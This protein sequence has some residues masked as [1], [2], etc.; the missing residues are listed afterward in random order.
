MTV[1]LRVLIVED[2]E[3]DALLLAEALREGGYEPEYERVDSAEALNAA[4]DAREWDVIL[5]DYSMPGFGGL[6]ALKITREKDPDIPFILVSGTVG[7]EIAV[8]AMRVGCHDYLLKSHL[9]R[10]VPAIEREMESARARWES[11]RTEEALRR[12][13]WLLRRSVTPTDAMSPAPSYGDLTELNTERTILDSVGRETLASIAGDAIDLLDTSVAIYERNGDYAL[14]VFASG[15]CRFLDEAARRLCGTDDNREA[16]TC[17]RWLCHEACW[18]ASAEAAIAGGRPTDVACPGGIRL[19]A[20][21]IRAGE[22]IIGAIN[23]GYGDPP[24]DPRQLERIAAKYGVD[25]SPLRAKAEE[26]RSRPKYVVELARKKL[27]F[28][29]TL[30]GEMVSRKRAEEALRESEGR[31]KEAQRMGRIGHW[32]FDIRT[33][34]IEWS[35]MVYEIYERDPA[36]GPPSEAEEALYYPPED[37]KRLR[38]SARKAIETGEPYELDVQ[39]NLPSGKQVDVVAMGKP[40]MDSDGDVIRLIGTVQDITQRKRAEEGLQTAAQQWTA[41]F[42]A[43]GNALCLLDVN[44]RIMRCNRAM[45]GLLEK[46][47]REIIGRPHWEILFGTADPRGDS[48]FLQLQQTFRRETALLQRG[49]RW[50]TEIVDPM[51]NEERRLVGAVYLLVDITERKRAEEEREKIQAQLLQSQKMEAVGT[52]AGGVAHDFNNQLTAI[53]GYTDLALMELDESDPLCRDL[54]QIRHAATRAADLTRQLLLFSRKQPMEVSTL[55]LNRTI[56]DMLKMLRRLIGEDIAIET[57][58]EPDPWSVR[59]DE[60]KIEQILMNL[61]VNARDAMPGGGTIT[62]RTENVHV[63]EEYA[64]AVPDARPGRFVRLSVQDTGVGMD[65]AIIPHIFEPFFT[66]KEAG[67][68]TG[69][70]LS[71]VYGIVKQH[72]GWVHVYSEPGEGTTFRIYLSAFSAKPE[73]E[74]EDRLSLEAYR[75]FGERILLAEDEE[76]VRTFAVQALRRN[77]YTVFEARDAGEALEIFDREGGDFHLLFSDVVLPDGSGLQL[78]EQL[79]ARKPDVP[80]IMS[81]GYMDNKSQWS[82]IKEKGFRFLQKPYF[83][84]DLLKAVKDAL[85]QEKG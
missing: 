18:H 6:H 26:Y 38:E 75:G 4:L 55:D 84:P 62:I 64:G 37:T 22:E 1:P 30:I 24:K 65:K 49:G 53:Q 42:N 15:W 81:S 19:Y 79:F 70:G 13:E 67:T 85:A 74:A 20:V 10:L 14:G 17:G 82:I 43:I 21:P 27:H 47:Y 2:S 44:G 73:E 56:R 54:M 5:A 76:G 41:T 78:T 71:V 77:G 12:I 11:R 63:E 33:R 40:V 9:R 52:L 68:G 32:S 59:A 51:L 16:L 60:G 36:L 34:Q 66:T 31:L 39:L 25:V 72:N 46:P 69:L 28:A 23:V 58:L 57:R 61:V 80:V 83:L 35:E 8:E 29:A 45:L 50:Y 48:A 3:D 7:E